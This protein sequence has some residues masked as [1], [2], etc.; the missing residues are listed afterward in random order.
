MPQTMLQLQGD[1]K[2]LIG[3]LMHGESITG[4]DAAKRHKE[5]IA[6]RPW[7]RT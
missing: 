2:H 1:S 7:V 4:E 3:W 5:L 6:S